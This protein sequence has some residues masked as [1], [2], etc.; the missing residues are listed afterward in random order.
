MLK[1]ILKA[2]AAIAAMFITM[3]VLM[4]VEG[5]LMRIPVIGKY[6]YLILYYPADAAWALLVT[7]NMVPIGTGIEVIEQLEGGRV[8]YVIYG[9]AAGLICASALYTVRLSNG[10]SYAVVMIMCLVMCIAIIFK[11]D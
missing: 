11:G 10:I 5:L 8:S 9:T 7:N 2:I 1:N 6:I 3:F 4:L